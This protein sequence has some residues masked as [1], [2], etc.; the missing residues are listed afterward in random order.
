MKI[1][2]NTFSKLLEIS[3]KS[4]Y[5]WK[6]KDHKLLVNL[7]DKYFTEDDIKEFIENNR[8]NRLDKFE[9]YI[10]K[11][12]LNNEYMKDNESSKY[13]AKKYFEFIKEIIHTTDEDIKE[14]NEIQG[15]DL[16]YL[17]QFIK[18]IKNEDNIV[19]KESYQFG[20]ICAYQESL[21]KFIM[22]EKIISFRINKLLKL[23]EAS[24]IFIENFL[25][26]NKDEIYGYLQEFDK[27]ICYINLLMSL[28]IND[29]INLVEFESMYKIQ[30]EKEMLD[31][32][33]RE[34]SITPFIA[35]N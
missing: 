19:N 29:K 26:K 31:I 9:K 34:K 22:E 14:N 18:K 12:I 17:A 11:N 5:R 6:S 24:I 10:N 1:N 13:I 2:A 27:R 23:D 8:I 15:T 35:K 32:F 21:I 30:S 33:E 20:Y 7:I 4:F 16:Y 3:E 25:I 28:Y